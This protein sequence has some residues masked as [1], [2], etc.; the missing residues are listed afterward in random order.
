MESKGENWRNSA[1]KGCGWGWGLREMERGED[2]CVGV[3]AKIK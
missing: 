1:S 2:V 3:A